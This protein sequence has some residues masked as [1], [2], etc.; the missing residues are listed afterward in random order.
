MPSSYKIRK[1]INPFVGDAFNPASVPELPAIRQVL[2]RAFSGGEIEAFSLLVIDF[3]CIITPAA[4]VAVATGH[5]PDDPD[6]SYVGPFYEASVIAALVGGGEVYIAETDETEKEIVGCAVWFGPGHSIYDSEAQRKYAL[7]PF[8]E[9]LSEEQR[10]WWQLEFVPKFRELVKNNLGDGTKHNAWHLQ[11]LGIDPAHRRK[12]LAKALMQDVIAKSTGVLKCLEFGTE[13]SNLKIY[14]KIGW[15]QAEY[16]VD[17]NSRR[18][19]C[20][21][22]VMTM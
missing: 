4:F 21:M 11:T 10:E 18:G 22:G 20:G 13:T 6:T 9:R 7:S 3:E 5:D 12:G 8:M 1:L 19:K 15:K 16:S 2:A 14:Q 17:F